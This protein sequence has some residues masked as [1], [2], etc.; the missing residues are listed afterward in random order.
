[1]GEVEAG[2][3]G[4]RGL[5]SSVRRT[6]LALRGSLDALCIAAHARVRGGRAALAP[7]NC[8]GGPRPCG[9]PGGEHRAAH[10][11]TT[12]VR[13]WCHESSSKGG[14][15]SGWESS[16]HRWG[17]VPGPPRGD[18]HTTASRGRGAGGGVCPGA[19]LF[20]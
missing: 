12:A 4:R 20:S 5:S 8:R 10:A 19:P 14:V 11:V 17:R 2:R 15:W 13:T 3:G 16:Q 6:A 9:R 1:M 18:P 7:H